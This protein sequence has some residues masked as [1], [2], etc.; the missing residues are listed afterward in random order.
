VPRTSERDT[1]VWII[2]LPK[3]SVHNMNYNDE[4]TIALSCCFDFAICLHFPLS[5]VEQFAKL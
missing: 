3:P 2:C 4:R 5:N 1:E